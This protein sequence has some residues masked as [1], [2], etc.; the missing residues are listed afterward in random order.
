VRTPGTLNV[1]YV[2]DEPVSDGRGDVAPTLRFTDGGTEFQ[3]RRG[4]S[5]PARTARVGE[6][7]ELGLTLEHPFEE[8]LWV[9]WMKYKGAGEASFEPAEQRVVL[10]R[11]SGVATV[12]VTFDS[13]GEYELLV[14]SINS[15]AA[16]EFHCCWTNGY[17]P[18]RV[19]E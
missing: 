14:Q 9:G 13:P 2:L 15:T 4:A 3:G 10:E 18:V 1:A 7:L 8:Q 16:F 17:V 19:V 11:G 5:A 6:P 12:R